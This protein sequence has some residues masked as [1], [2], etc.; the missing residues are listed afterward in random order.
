MLDQDA[1]Q[2]RIREAREM[3][4]QTTVVPLAIALIGVIAFVIVIIQSG[5][6]LGVP[7]TIRTLSPPAGEDL[8]LR[9][10]ARG[11]QVYE[12]QRDEAL[13]RWVLVGPDAVLTDDLGRTIGKH[14]EGPTWE[15]AD[16]S[17]VEGRVVGSST[18]DPSAIPHLLLKAKAHRGAGVFARVTSI[19]RLNTV[20]G[21]A[22]MDG[23]G[24]G[25]IGRRT[26]VRYTATYYFYED[27]RATS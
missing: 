8:V 22:P 14:Y 20:G 25:D 15:S 6:V 11:V 7:L 23:C 21:R 10:F 26:R 2:Q 18:A 12:C 1:I 4:Q 16:G 27:A 13:A 17:L 9:A 24:E 3:Q 19:Q 5:P